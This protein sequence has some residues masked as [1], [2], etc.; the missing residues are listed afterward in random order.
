M[1]RRPGTNAE[2]GQAIAETVIFLPLFLFAL[3]GTIWVVQATV[4]YERTESAIRYFAQVS[5]IS[6]PYANYSF[7]SMFG[8][9]GSNTLPTLMCNAPDVDA[10]SMAS[11]TYA[12]KNAQNTTA[13]P[14][15]WSPSTTPTAQCTQATYWGMQQ[16]VA[17][18]QNNSMDMLFITKI[19]KVTSAVSVPSQLSAVL[20]SAWSTT[21][22]EVIFDQVG[23]NVLVA[24]YPSF[25]TQL[26]ASI[27]YA[28]D[29]SSSTS[30][31]P[32]ALNGDTLLTADE[33]KFDFFTV[34][35]SCL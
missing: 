2:R 28:T 10:L 16:N 26:N 9:L 25:N 5:E 8:Q 29:T 12:S 13:S 17:Q 20:G 15:F 30:T 4:Q 7:A 33:G 21:N 11:T 14:P 6:S 32:A 18:M 23:L 1:S 34:S 24:C 35:P 3:F 19:P 27:N 31:V 22:S